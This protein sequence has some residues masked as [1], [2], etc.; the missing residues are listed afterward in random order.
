MF[1]PALKFPRERPK[2]HL[3]NKPL[4]APGVLDDDAGSLKIVRKK[5]K[6]LL[7][8]RSFQGKFENLGDNHSEKGFIFRYTSKPEEVY[9]YFNPPMNYYVS[10]E[11]YEY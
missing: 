10:Y 7:E 11:S 5:Q 4:P 3:A 1:V 6:H 2:S 8:K 9:L